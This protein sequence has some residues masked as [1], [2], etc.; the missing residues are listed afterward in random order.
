[1]RFST[2]LVFLCLS[3]QAQPAQPVTIGTASR[4]IIEL[5]VEKQI[6]DGADAT[7]ALN[8]PQAIKLLEAALKRIRANPAALKKMEDRCLIRLGYAYLGALRLDDALRAFTPIIGPTG[9]CKPKMKLEDCADAQYGL[10]T[11]QMYKSDFA[12]AVHNLGNAQITFGK[13]AAAD[14]ETRLHKILQQAKVE[15]LLGAALFRT[16]DKPK[17]IQTLR[18]SVTQL[19]DLQKNAQ[20]QPAERNS[21]QGALADAQNS[22]KLL[23]QN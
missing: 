6:N 1:M 9:N 19:T 18:H 12:A 14:P 7:A 22:L 3:A 4:P 5:E 20:L 8:H 10:G 23:L 16:G 11:A 15:G 2:L 21:A 13:A 17:A